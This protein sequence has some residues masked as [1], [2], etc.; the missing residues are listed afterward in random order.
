MLS[1]LIKRQ[2]ATCESFIK[3]FQ[4]GLPYADGPAFHQDKDRIRQLRLEREQW[5]QILSIVTE[6]AK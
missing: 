5:E 6:A 2:I 1:T 3:N 4:D